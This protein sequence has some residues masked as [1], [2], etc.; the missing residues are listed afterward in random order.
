[1]TAPALPLVERLTA[2]RSDDTSLTNG[3]TNHL[4]MTLAALSALGADAM[5]LDRFTAH[6]RGQVRPLP[7]APAAVASPSLGDG[8]GYPAW[9]DF[10]TGQIALQGPEQVLADW[11]PALLEGISTAAFHGL[12]RLAYG[13]RFACATEMAGG[14]AM[15]AAYRTLTPLPTG[16]GSTGA[17]EGLRALAQGTALAEVRFEQPMI[18][19]R[20]VEVMRHPAFA[21]AV[22]PLRIEKGAD[23]AWSS[24]ALA[25]TRLYRATADFS[26]LHLITALHALQV[27]WPFMRDHAACLQRFWFAFCAVYVAIGRPWPMAY[28]D[29]GPPLDWPTLTQVALNST[30]EHVIKLVE[31]CHAMAATLDEAE[32]DLPLQLRRCASLLVR[33]G[34]A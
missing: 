16:V 15:L 27:L 20:L 28:A 4:P 8:T 17:A 29:D 26:A 6:Y 11:L 22:S 10:F 18:M 12:I 2:L 1:M 21:A 31:S 24:L 32:S 34:H 9:L 3:F 13:V 23:R 19:R 7:P 25:A 33:R 30:D 5:V 14:L